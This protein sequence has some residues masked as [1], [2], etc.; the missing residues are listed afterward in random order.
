[1][2]PE[3]LIERGRAASPLLLAV[4]VGIVLTFANLLPAFSRSSALLALLAVLIW[5]A[6]AIALFITVTWLRNDEWWMAGCIVGLTPVVARLVA[7]VIARGDFFSSTAPTIGLLVRAAVAVPL[8][9]G[10]VFGARWLT[11]W[12]TGTEVA[13]R[14][15]QR[16]A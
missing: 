7:E 11:E 15:K 3:N 1:M 12:I 16:R 14:R 5:F 6:A 13:P 2:E 9:G 10:V 8:C 4:P